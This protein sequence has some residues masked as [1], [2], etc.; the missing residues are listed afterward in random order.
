MSTRFFVVSDT[1]FTHQN[2]LSFKRADGTPLRDFR[3]VGEMDELMIENWNK[4]VRPQDHVWHLG[5]VAM[6]RQ[7]LPIVRRLN[8]HKRLIMGNHDIFEVKEYL[9]AGFQKIMGMRVI[10]GMLLTHVPVHPNSL[11]RFS[12]NI[13]GHLHAGSVL[14]PDGTPD[15]RY[16]SVCVEKTNYSPIPLENLQKLKP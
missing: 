13:H 7:L 11:G 2:I 16:V 14:Q 10:D 6:R 3:S 5:D 9:A 12:L 4:L 15:P 1:H 8:G